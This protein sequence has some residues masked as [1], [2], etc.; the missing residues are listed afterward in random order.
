MIHGN[1][2]FG[3]NSQDEGGFFKRE[4]SS[5]I[6]FLQKGHAPFRSLSAAGELSLFLSCIF[7]HLES[8]GMLSLSYILIV[9]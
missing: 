2:A 4:K 8:D 1:S 3:I 9:N 7:I 5:V 6:F